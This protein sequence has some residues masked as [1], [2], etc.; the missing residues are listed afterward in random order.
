MS[1][2]LRKL[3]RG[4][5]Y[6]TLAAIVSERTCRD[7]DRPDAGVQPL[8]LD[9]RDSVS[10]EMLVYWPKVGER[11]LVVGVSVGETTVFLMRGGRVAARM[12]VDPARP[13]FTL[14]ALVDHAW[15]WVQEGR[16]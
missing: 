3:N 16:P 14:V 9:S 11:Q 6:E 5:V 13:R 1:T 2:R 8:P 7:D 15:K 10:G 12:S 4:R